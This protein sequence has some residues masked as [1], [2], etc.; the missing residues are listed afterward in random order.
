MN[1]RNGGSNIW[2]AKMQINTEF[3]DSLSSFFNG[4]W[5]F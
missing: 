1:L 2:P 5:N 3:D 4:S